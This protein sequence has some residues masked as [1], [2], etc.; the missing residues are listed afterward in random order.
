MIERMP[1][2]AYYH[3]STTAWEG[4]RGTSS[5]KPLCTDNGEVTGLILA[6]QGRINQ[7]SNLFLRKCTE[8]IR[9]GSLTAAADSLGLVWP[10]VWKRVR[11]LEDYLGMQLVEPHARVP[12]D[13]GRPI[14][15]G[16]GPSPGSSGSATPIGKMPDRSTANSWTGCPVGPSPGVLSSRSSITAML[17]PPISR[18]KGRSSVT[19]WGPEPGRYPPPLRTLGDDGQAEFGPALSSTATGLVR[20]LSRVSGRPFR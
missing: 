13:G 2:E 5:D 19:G 1:R 10:T 15:G 9:L 16:T 20:R 7:I 6:T 18:R 11:S 12:T 3:T 17:T 14:A 4:G 8:T